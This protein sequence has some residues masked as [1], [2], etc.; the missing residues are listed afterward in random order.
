MQGGI[1][2]AIDLGTS[3]TVAV[4]QRGDRAPQPVLFDGPPL[5][6]SG[7]CA[8]ERGA[9]HAGRDAERLA[10]AAPHRFEPHPKR[11][12][13]DGTVLLGDVE[14]PV[15]QLLAAVLRRVKADAGHAG[16][17]D[18]RETVLTCP[19]DWG[20]RRREILVE[21]ARLAGIAAP[22]FVDEPVAA[23]AYCLH[24]LRTPVAPGRPLLIFDFGGGTL[25]LA[26]VRAEPG[27]ARVVGIGGLEDLGGLDVDAALAGHLGHLI[28]AR[29]D[30]AW[31]RIAQPAS[32]AELRERRAFWAEVR[33]AKEMLSRTAVAPVHLPG[34]GQPLH[35]TREE[36]ERLAG[37]LIDRALDETRRVLAGCGLTGPALAAMSPGVSASVGAPALAAM[38][39]GVSASAGAPALAAILLVGGSSRIPL[40]AS[41]LHGRFG[42]APV[43]PEQPELPVALG[44]LAALYGAGPIGPVGPTGAVWSPAATAEL[45]TPTSIPVSGAGAVPVSA[46]PIGGPIAASVSAVPAASVSAPGSPPPAPSGHPPG[47]PAPPGP[48]PP[49]PPQPAGGHVPG[50]PPAPAPARRTGGPAL[51]AMTAAVLLLFLAVGAAGFWWL[52]RDD[53]GASAGP[54]ESAGPG[55]SAPAPTRPSRAA[56]PGFAW[57]EGDAGVFCPTE[58]M[59]NDSDDDDVACDQP[60]VTQV[61]A[62]GYLPDSGLGTRTGELLKLPEVKKG[63][64][65]EVMTARSVDRA[66]TAN[67]ARYVQHVWQ[68]GTSMFVCHAG[69]RDN[70]EW[71]GSAF[72]TG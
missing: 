10:Q 48:Y 8:D 44:A 38:S 35:L 68:N 30:A 71:T 53:G 46:V 31:R 27:G 42:V 11:R 65:D 64:S 70:K 19:A 20:Q 59:C 4:V 66:R 34:A 39:P 62:A 58:P 13:D 7:V 51:V 28:A 21:A 57:C 9:L 22:R 16:G 32:A 14:V 55:A 33:A 29:D 40:V 37:P 49:W 47:V 72:R 26:V 52:G 50:L 6:L 56:P 1:R 67:W 12:I 3:H 61:Y 23:A 17:A 15:P 18:A 54:A 43:V 45:A 24:V 69:P 41:R 25:D 63:C 2:M 5:L 36:V 60:H